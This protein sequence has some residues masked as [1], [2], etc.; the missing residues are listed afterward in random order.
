MLIHYLK[1]AWRNLLKYKAQSVISIVGL[2]ISFTAFTFTLS[3][4]RYERGYDKHIPD[5]ERIFRVFVKDST[6]V[7][8]IQPYAPN[9]LAAYLKEKYPEIE[10]A[11]GL[12]AYKTNIKQGDEI[13]LNQSACINI[14]TSFFAVFYPEIKISFPISWAPSCSLF[15]ALLEKM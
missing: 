10:A 2:S 14:D 15:A 4:I 12:Y 1:I 13:V 7:D 9:A 11:T 5:A 3:W 6:K 8:G